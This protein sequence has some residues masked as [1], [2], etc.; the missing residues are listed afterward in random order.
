VEIAVSE[1]GWPSMRHDAA[2]IS[3]DDQLRLV[4][5]L[6]CLMKTRRV[7]LKLGDIVAL[8]PQ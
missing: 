8:F 1:T 6:P 5:C 2:T 3:H 7:E 4:I